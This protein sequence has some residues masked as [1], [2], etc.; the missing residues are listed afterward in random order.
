M[1]RETKRSV[2]RFRKWE[3]GSCGK[4]CYKR[5]MRRGW[6]EWCRRGEQNRGERREARWVVSLAITAVIEQWMDWREREGETSGKESDG[7]QTTK[8]RIKE[9]R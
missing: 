7:F 6:I 8:R 4:P 5:L 3:L 2:E 1:E 9:E